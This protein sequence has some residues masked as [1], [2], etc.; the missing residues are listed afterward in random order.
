MEL[1]FKHYGAEV[2]DIEFYLSKDKEKI[3]I[4]GFSYT[5]IDS[6][7]L[8]E[9][10]DKVSTLYSNGGH[11]VETS[12]NDFA[13]E[14]VVDQ[15]TTNYFYQYNPRVL[16]QNTILALNA[17]F[18]AEISSHPLTQL[19]NDLH[20]IPFEK[21]DELFFKYQA[22]KDNVY[23]YLND[24]NLSTP[25]DFN[26][27]YEK[28]SYSV[29]SYQ[30]Y[31]IEN[32]YSDTF[33]N[34][35]I[36]NVASNDFVSEQ[37]YYSLDNLFKDLKENDLQTLRETIIDHSLDQ[38]TALFDDLKHYNEGDHSDVIYTEYP[39]KDFIEAIKEEIDLDD[40]E[41][42]E[43]EFDLNNAADINGNHEYYLHFGHTYNLSKENH[44]ANKLN[45]DSLSKNELLTFIE[46]KLQPSNNDLTLG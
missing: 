26:I 31:L 36:E 20:L 3:I 30:K 13:E 40:F 21:M 34:N 28:E 38:I 8:D 33:F 32:A 22:H 5:S 12:S 6:S 14:Y 18:D 41:Y 19:P 9:Y 1:T 7:D 10:L 46:E 17:D 43:I 45:Y 27:L 25:V 44:T 37:A 11:T 23:V 35:D 2:N 4:T 16:Y 39:V 42:A 15:Y 24:L 29:A